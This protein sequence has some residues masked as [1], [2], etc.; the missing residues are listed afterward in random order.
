MSGEN[1][2]ARHL[3]SVPPAEEGPFGT[4]DDPADWCR[5]SISILSSPSGDVVLLDVR[6]DLDAVTLPGVTAALD[7][8]LGLPA[9]HLVVSLAGLRFCSMRGLE[10]FVEGRATAARCGIGFSVSG[11]SEQMRRLWSILWAVDQRP[12]QFPDVISAVDDALAP[13]AVR[14]L[15]HVGGPARRPV[16]RLAEERDGSRW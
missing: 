9:V 6:G 10:L 3:R 15:A 1:E 12:T 11:P 16:V 7:A 2:S 5:C 4:G 14:Y 8:A 13:R